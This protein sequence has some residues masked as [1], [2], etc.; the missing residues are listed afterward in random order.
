MTTNTT[1]YNY[2]TTKRQEHT[3][4]TITQHTDY[5]FENIYKHQDLIFDDDFTYYIWEHQHN[6]AIIR[7][8]TNIAI[9]C[10]ITAKPFTFYLHN[11]TEA[12]D[13]HNLPVDHP[14][15]GVITAEAPHDFDPIYKIWQTIIFHYE[16]YGWVEGAL[17]TLTQH[18]LNITGQSAV[19]TQEQLLAGILYYWS[20]NKR[21]PIETIHTVFRRQPPGFYTELVKPLNGGKDKQY[22]ED[23]RKEHTNHE[24]SNTH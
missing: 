1:W 9:T 13:K 19:R 11:I 15:L 7:A 17:L 22:V 6:P 2:S 16:E 5:T 21:I 23:V 3:Y 12:C 10:S 8:I 4:H 18:D 24:S 20:E 14:I